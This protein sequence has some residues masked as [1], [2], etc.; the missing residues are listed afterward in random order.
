MIGQARPSAL[1]A[2]LAESYELGQA[3]S[4]LVAQSL[5]MLQSPKNHAAVLGSQRWRSH[6]RHG[7]AGI[8]G[9]TNAARIQA[10]LQEAAWHCLTTFGPMSV[11]WEEIALSMRYLT[12]GFL[13]G[14]KASW[15]CKRQVD[16]QLG[17]QTGVAQSYSIAT[18]GNWY[19]I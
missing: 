17:H 19:M 15:S 14:R 13:A 8:G 7:G 1:A 3:T 6:G 2:V 16:Q 5:A 18:N 9:T 10:A 12:G 11:C 4:L